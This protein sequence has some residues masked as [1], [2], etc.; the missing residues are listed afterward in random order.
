ME[1]PTIRT[2]RAHFFN[3]VLPLHGTMHNQDQ[4]FEVD[5]LGH[6]VVGAHLHRFYRG[7]Y[8]AKRCHHDDGRLHSLFR[9]AAE[10]FQSGGRHFQVSDDELGLHLP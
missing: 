1:W 4:G 6:V 5:R 10:K 3:Q 2:K 9:N 7:F 8:G